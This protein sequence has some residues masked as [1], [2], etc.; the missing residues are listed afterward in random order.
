MAQEAGGSWQ[1][2]VRWPEPGPPNPS[3]AS[4]GLRVPYG[5]LRKLAGASWAKPGRLLAPGSRLPFP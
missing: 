5:R 4:C 3:P 1:E 2:S